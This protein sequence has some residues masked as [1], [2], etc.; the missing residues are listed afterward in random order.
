M[1]PASNLFHLLMPLEGT[2]FVLTKHGTLLCGIE[3][4]GKDPSGMSES[5]YSMI[6]GGLSMLY[7]RLPNNVIVTQYYSHFDGVKIHFRKRAHPVSNYLSERRQKFLNQQN[8]SGSK[9]ILTLE[10]LPAENLCNL[11][12]KSL[13]KHLLLSFSSKKSQNIIK[14]ACSFDGLSFEKKYVYLNSEVARQKEILKTS[15]D[16]VCKMLS[17]FCASKVLSLSEL[18][19]HGRFLASGMQ[20]RLQVKD[21]HSF[22]PNHWDYHLSSA[23]EIE[24]VT[25]GEQEDQ[26]IKIADAEVRYLQIASVRSFGNPVIEGCW[27]AR[28]EAPTRLSGNYVIMNR[29]QPLGEFQR[30]NL[31]RNKANEIVRSKFK[32]MDVL[33]GDE[34]KSILE[35]QATESIKEKELLEELQ[36]AENLQ[37][38]WGYFASHVMVFGKTAE[39]TK[40]QKTRLDSAMAAMRISVVWEKPGLLDAFKAIQLGSSC[41]GY[42]NMPMNT[43]KVGAA[44][45]FFQSARGQPIVK[46]LRG[47]EAQ[48]ILVSEDGKPFYFSPFINRRGFIFSSAPVGR[49]KSHFKKA[50]AMHFMK[51]GGLY[52]SLGIDNGDE[53]LA[54]VFPGETGVFRIGSE[55]QDS[56]INPFKSLMHWDSEHSNAGLMVEHI[57]QLMQLFLRANDDPDLRVLAPG[58]QDELDNKIAETLAENKLEDRS[59]SGL[60]ARLS[61][62]LKKKFKRWVHDVH[63]GT[64]HGRYANVWGSDEDS[65]GA[66]DQRIAVFNLENIKDNKNML[67]P[68]LQELTFRIT[69]AFNNPALLGVPKMLDIDEAHVALKIDSM[70]EYLTHGVRTWGKKFASIA[71]WTQSVSELQ[72]VKNWDALRTAFTT[73]IFFS[74][75]ALAEKHSHYDVQAVARFS[76]ICQ[77][78]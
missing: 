48:Y 68:V 12:M 1:K 61:E 77:P 42:R 21:P 20:T 69:S 33:R 58:E 18:W 75:S 71:L 76:L 27:A 38:K 59:L 10:V 15:A 8:L 50:I 6:A 36:Q 14:N 37:D 74:G 19:A 40:A 57:S 46:D 56:H 4:A 29:W 64:K 62:P 73:L 5:D 66:L 3:L 22:P 28:D 23:G 13:M 2:D 7:K 49:G 17:I 31:F 67:L 39:E 41:D 60:V 78:N 53:N 72:E 63:G 16:L 32:L 25:H 47:E 11:G 70:S 26:F 65:I 52:R 54:D 35:K 30:S 55:T 44:S 24:P 9:I 51:Y 34:E 45:L 43:R